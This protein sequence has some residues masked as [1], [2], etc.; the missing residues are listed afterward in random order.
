[1]K[2]VYPSILIFFFISL[3]T[4]ASWAAPSWHW[5][6]R[7]SNAEQQGLINWVTH[8]ED[9]MRNLYGPLPFNYRAYF[10]RSNS[11]SGPSPWA[12]TDK[13]YGKA[14][15]FHVNTANSWNKFMRDWTAPHELSHLMFPY[16]G[17]NSIW[18]AE[19]LASYLQYQIMYANN[20]ISW[21]KG[22]D[23]LEERFNRARKYRNYDQISIVELSKIVRQTGAYVRLYWGGAA[24]FMNAD[25]RLAKEKNMR[26]ST[27]I[28]KYLDCCI[29]QR[30]MNSKSM[31]KTFDKLSNSTIF[32]EVYEETVKKD[33]FPKTQKALIWLKKNPPELIRNL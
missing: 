10:H 1:M 23:K 14:V 24:Y 13:S 19:G 21:K 12:H 29:Q 4:G 18:F 16:L 6:D 27:V 28:R 2:Q 7:F 20:T 26:L 15:H 8:A 32:S 25:Y 22:T 17:E 33:G 5:E 31:I 3:Y 11:G 30:Y 9:G